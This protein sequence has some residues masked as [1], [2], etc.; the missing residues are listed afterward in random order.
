MQRSIIINVTKVSL[1][2]Y[3]IHEED[4]LWSQGKCTFVWVNVP[5]NRNWPTTASESHRRRIKN[6][7]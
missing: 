7:Y 1:T 4:N 5:E 2:V 6:K 3:D